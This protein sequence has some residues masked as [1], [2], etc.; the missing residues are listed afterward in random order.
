MHLP[1]LIF[2]VFFAFLS[3]CL[4]VLSFVVGEAVGVGE[5][6]GRQLRDN[7]FHLVLTSPLAAYL[8]RV[9]RFVSTNGTMDTVSALEQTLR[10]LTQPESQQGQTAWNTGP[11]ECVLPL[12]ATL[13]WISQ[14]QGYHKGLKQYVS[15]ALFR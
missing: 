11:P 12:S 1:F 10:F 8:L 6:P 5:I 3:P 15:G 9:L 2:A 14:L 7:C 4:A 13:P